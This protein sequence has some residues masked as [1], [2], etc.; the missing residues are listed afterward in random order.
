VGGRKRNPF[1]GRCFIPVG[2]ALTACVVW[3]SAMYCEM[4]LASM[5]DAAVTAEPIRETRKVTET[6]HAVGQ[7]AGFSSSWGL[8]QPTIITEFFS[9]AFVAFAE[10][11]AEGDRV[12]QL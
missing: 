4:P 5:A 1:L 11:S 6:L 7:L 8:A 12:W 9:L 3:N 10:P 2:R